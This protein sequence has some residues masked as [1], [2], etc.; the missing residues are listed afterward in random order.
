MLIGPVM[1]G[2]FVDIQYHWS[3]WS[4]LAGLAMGMVLCLSILIRMARRS[5]DDDPDSESKV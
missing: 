5:G 1:I 4:T 3:P 2:I